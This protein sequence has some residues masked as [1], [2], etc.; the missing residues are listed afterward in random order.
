MERRLFLL[1]TSMLLGIITDTPWAQRTRSERNLDDP[2]TV[3]TTSVVCHGE[4]MAISERRKWSDKKREKLVKLLYEVPAS[5]INRQPI[6]NAYARINV[7]THGGSVVDQPA[8]PPKPA[9]SMT[10]NDLW[11]AATAH[12]TDATLLSTDRD[13]EHL[14][15]VWIDFIY[16]DQ[17]PQ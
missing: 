5:G 17:R 11:I 8:P 14:H 9:V 3:V 1:D 6:L 10:D 12:V 7:W 2:R 16:V 4:I 13:F 15:S